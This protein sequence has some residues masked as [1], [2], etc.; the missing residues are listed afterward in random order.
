MSYSF[1]EIRIGTDKTT[2]ET[3]FN[4]RFLLFFFN[5]K[6]YLFKS[7]SPEMCLC[8]LSHIL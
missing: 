4:A 2:I 7:V 1:H 6:L 8:S 5:L 3:G